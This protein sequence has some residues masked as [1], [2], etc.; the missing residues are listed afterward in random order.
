VLTPP[1]EFEAVKNA[2]E[3]AGLKPEVAEVTMRA[4][5]PIEL[6]GDDA[7]RMRK[8]LDVLEDLDDVQEVYHNAEIDE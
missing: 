1:T 3:K 7:A 6:K 5:T 4:E 2:L 8:L